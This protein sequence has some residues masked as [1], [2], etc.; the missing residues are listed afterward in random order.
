MALSIM[1]VYIA[2]LFVAAALGAGPAN[3]LPASVGASLPGF[4]VLCTPTGLRTM[5]FD[6]GRTDDASA[7]HNGQ[8]DCPICAAT[9]KLP[10]LAAQPIEPIERPVVYAP[11]PWAPASEAPAERY[12]AAHF[13]SRAPPPHGL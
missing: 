9:C 11:T 10:L 4:I 8:V 6:D 1:A 7:P 13:H 3:A 5:A 2:K 12:A